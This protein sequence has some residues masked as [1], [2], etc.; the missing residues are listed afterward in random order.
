[1]IHYQVLVKQTFY[2][3]VMVNP[4]NVNIQD[5]PRKTSLP[6]VLHMSLLLY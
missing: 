1:L 6:S 4:P 3:G 2:R 5:G